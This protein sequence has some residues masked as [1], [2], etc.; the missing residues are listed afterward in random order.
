MLFPDVYVTKF[1]FKYGLDKAPGSLLELGC[2]NG[3]NARLF[4]EYGWQ[5]TGIDVDPTAI[6][7]AC[8]NWDQE[9]TDAWAFIER[10]LRDGLPELEGPF[11]AL[12][13]NGSLLYFERRYLEALLDQARPLLQPGAPIHVKLRTVEDW[14]YGRGDLVEADTFRLTVT[15]TGEAGA[16]MAFYTPEGIQE[17]LETHL[18]PLTDVQRLL[19]RHDNVQNGVHVEN[20]DVV[21]WGRLADEG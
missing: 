4:T 17:I 6:A 13:A 20:R 8:A 11:D 9:P 1:F 2:G 16:V 18:G 15:E 10:D 12:V 3:N 19:E 21:V 14:R 5:V 7:N